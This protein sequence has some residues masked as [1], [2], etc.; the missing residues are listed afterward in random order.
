MSSNGA[1]YPLPYDVL[2]DFEPIALIASNPQLIVAKNA[3]PAKDL[4]D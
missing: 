2:N 1:I 3:M 4:K